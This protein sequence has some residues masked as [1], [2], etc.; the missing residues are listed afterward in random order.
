MLWQM[1]PL[2]ILTSWLQDHVGDKD[3]LFTQKDLVS[4]CPDLSSGAFKTLLS[5]AADQGII[6]RICRGLYAYKAQSH[7]KGRLLF[8]AASYLRS[9]CFNYISLETALSEAGCISQIPINWITIMSSGRT[10]RI[11]CGRFG[12]IEFVHTTITP[13]KLVD[14]LTYDPLCNLWRA[15]I[16]L[17]LRDMKKTHRNC[18]LIDWKTVHELV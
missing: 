3:Y 2:K 5:R 11:S 1:Q 10:A 4:L 9:H 8:H 7:A 17:A 13:S 12:T 15:N 16:E 6:D 18:D 14:R